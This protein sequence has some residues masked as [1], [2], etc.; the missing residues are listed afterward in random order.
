MK[1]NFLPIVFTCDDKYFKYTMVVISSIIANNNK[2]TFYEINILSQFIS[3]E[4]KNIAYDFIKKYNN[5]SIKFLILEDFDESQFYL[6][7]KVSYINATTYYRFY[8]PHL[9]R[10]YERVLY[11]DSDMIVD[12][13]ISA[14][15]EM[16]FE[17]RLA[18]VVRDGYVSYLLET[19]NESYPKDYFYNTL[20]MSNP[21]DYFNA[22]MILFNIP[23]I[24]QMEIDKKLFQALHD[25]GQPIYQDQDIINAVFSKNGGVKYISP[26]YNYMNRY[27]ASFLPLF[28]MRL[29]SL[30]G[31]KTKK[32]FRIIHFLSKS[33]PWNSHIPSAF[34]FYKYLF[35]IHLP[36]PPQSI[37]EQILSEN[38]K[39]LH[40]IKRLFLTYLS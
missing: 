24:N 20:K 30:L 12:S 13:D 5:F 27:N 15:A 18:I 21:K 17:E 19:D 9:F 40:P 2:D 26:K 28:L 4:N 8:I 25:I 10:K 7:Q 11:L 16:D 6:N 33:K 32:T 29:K 37:V 3:K 31:I 36:V 22:G 1:N 34:L 38:E 14:L 35:S 39:K 23:K